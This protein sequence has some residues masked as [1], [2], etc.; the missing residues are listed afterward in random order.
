MPPE[1]SEQV[2][3][4]VVEEPT[5]PLTVDITSKGT[6]GEGDVGIAPATFE[7]QADIAGGT[8]PYSYRWD[9]DGDG[10]SSEESDDDRVDHTF[11]EAGTYSVGITVT[12]SAGQTASDSIQIIVEEAL[13]E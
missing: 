5:N 6:E 9:F 12:D 7:F 13:A 11:E 4:E 2:Q 8:E 3:Q 10:T 1:Q